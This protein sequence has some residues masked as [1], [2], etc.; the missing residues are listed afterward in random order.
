M[1]EI[2]MRAPQ[3]PRASSKRLN[4]KPDANGKSNGVGIGIG[5]GIGIGMW[6]GGARFINLLI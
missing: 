2:V 4:E 6:S 5:I 3:V 1:N